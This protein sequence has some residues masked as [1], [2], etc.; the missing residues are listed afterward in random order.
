MQRIHDTVH[1]LRQKPEPVRKRI[2]L[3]ASAGLTALIGLVWASALL[4]SDR[5]TLAPRPIAGAAEPA[6]EPAQELR[7]SFSALMGAV[8]AVTGATTSPPELTVIDGRT[9]STIEQPAPMPSATVIPF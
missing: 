6:P 5:L 9:E 3:G 4:A 7:S 8:G 2:A 1:S